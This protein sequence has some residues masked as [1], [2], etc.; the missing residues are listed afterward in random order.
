MIRAKFAPWVLVFFGAALP[1]NASWVAPFISELHYDNAGG[2]VGEFVAVTGPSGLDL[3]SWQLALYNGGDGRVYR[4]VVLSGVLGGNSGALGEA[5]WPLGGMQNGPDAVALIS[6]LDV[7]FDF[8]AYEAGVVATDGAAQGLS[9]QLL[10]LA[11]DGA[12]PVGHS[13]QRVGGPGDP[14]WIAA[15]ATP[16]IVNPGLRET[17]VHVLPSLGALGLW[18]AG[19][20]GWAAVL[21]GRRVRPAA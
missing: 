16:G 3:S 10:P 20:A 6:P 11:E 15:T 9:A 13:L 14:S 18:G 12:T 5:A 1:V 2:D 4:S 17:Q 21:F 7:V 8:I 19:L